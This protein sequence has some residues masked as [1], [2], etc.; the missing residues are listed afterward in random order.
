MVPLRTKRG[1]DRVGRG[2]V[3]SWSLLEQR[4]VGDRIGIGFVRGLSHLAQRGGDG[5]GRGSV[6]DGPN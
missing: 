1:G 2:S 4:G 3:K 5:G 6:G